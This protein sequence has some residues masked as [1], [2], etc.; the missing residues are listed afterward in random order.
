[1]TDK[2]KG[3]HKT[4]TIVQ[5]ITSNRALIAVAFSISAFYVSC[6]SPTSVEKDTFGA[7]R[8]I[9]SLHIE[10]TKYLNGDEWTE[11]D[12]MSDGSYE[13]YLQVNSNRLG[14]LTIFGDTCY[15]A[16]EYDYNMRG[17][18]IISDSFDVYKDLPNWKQ[19]SI[20]KVTDD[21]LLYSQIADYINQGDSVYEEYQ[22]K[23]ERVDISSFPS[24]SNSSECLFLSYS[25]KEKRR[26]CAGRKCQTRYRHT[27]AK[28][29][30]LRT[31]PSLR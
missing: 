13:S 19:Y 17:D 3:Q 7:W 25:K 9:Y 23:F 1:M 15:S 30:S 4:L 29:C 10:I 24:T 2:G 14:Y 26:N 21:I 22:H 20:M 18:T 27:T 8:L 31:C 28:W 11:I 5:S 12:T 16:Y 6:N